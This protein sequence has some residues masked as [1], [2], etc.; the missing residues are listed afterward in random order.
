MLKKIYAERPRT[1]LY[2]DVPPQAEI[3]TPLL[4]HT[5][6][7]SP[8]TQRKARDVQ[9]L[10]TE[11]KISAES[12]ETD[13]ALAVEIRDAIEMTAGKFFG[14]RPTPESRGRCLGDKTS[15]V[16]RRRQGTA[17]RLRGDRALPEEKLPTGISFP[18]H[19]QWL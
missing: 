7:M 4:I 13:V 16:R 3:W 19:R 17:G 2:D 1:G 18:K 15:E 6:L 9:K 11:K 8:E 14:C 5:K 10:F 12:Q